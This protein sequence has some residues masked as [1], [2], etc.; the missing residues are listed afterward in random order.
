ML[1]VCYGHQP[2]CSSTGAVL[3]P[4]PT[5]LSP[6]RPIHL[7]SQYLC[8]PPASAPPR[9]ARP[10]SPPP[11]LCAHV[12]CCPHAAAVPSYHALLVQSHPALRLPLLPRPRRSHPTTASA[13]RAYKPPL[14]SASSRPLPGPPS[15]HTRPPRLSIVAARVNALRRLPRAPPRGSLRTPPTSASLLLSASALYL[16]S[17]SPAHANDYLASLFCNTHIAAR[18]RSYLSRRTTRLRLHAPIIILRPHAV[19]LRPRAPPTPPLYPVPLVPTP[20]LTP[21]VPVPPTP[22]TPPRHPGSQV[23][24]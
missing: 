5:S 21:L 2:P 3:L 6:R 9:L 22:S 11:R 1:P 23:F 14:A 4:V 24:E 17:A 10:A 16:P 15:S 7:V 20:C 13:A 8:A 19:A 18:L 12:P